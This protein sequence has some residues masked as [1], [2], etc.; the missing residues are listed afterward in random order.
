M[1]REPTNTIWQALSTRPEL[2]GFVLVG[3]SALA[4]HLDHRISEDLDFAWPHPKL[5]RAVLS[6]LPESLEK[7]SLEPDQDPL[8]E[9]EADDANL[10]LND[11]SQTF[12]VNGLVKVTFFCVD[13][14]ARRVLEQRDGAPLRLATVPEIFALK[15]LLT[16]KR[17]KARDWFDLYVMMK[18]HGFTWRNFYDAF[19]RGGAEGQYD[20][21]ANRLCSAQPS[22]EDEGYEALLPNPPSIDE[23]RAFFS[24]RR[25][26][27]ERG[28]EP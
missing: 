12:V 22:S 14:A 25:D 28:E 3:G 6:Q 21:A 20:H 13:L 7:L 1:L 8:A 2:R 11:F 17:A 18:F 16:A 9:R 23:M 19:V 10:D 24:Q 4:L 5:P 27:Y 15:S 26:A